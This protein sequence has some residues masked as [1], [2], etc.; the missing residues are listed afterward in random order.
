MDILPQ[1]NMAAIHSL[2]TRELMRLFPCFVKETQIIVSCVN[3]WVL[4]LNI[5]LYHKDYA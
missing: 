5:M 4:I 3:Y 2:I 1:E